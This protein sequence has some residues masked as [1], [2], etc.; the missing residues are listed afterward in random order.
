MVTSVFLVS[1]W[2][3]EGCLVNRMGRRMAWADK[4][5]VANTSACQPPGGHSG[6]APAANWKAGH[7]GSKQRWTRSYKAA[8]CTPAREALGGCQAISTRTR[9][10][11]TDGTVGAGPRPVNQSVRASAGICER[12]GRKISKTFPP[13]KKD[14]LESQ[15]HIFV[16]MEWQRQSDNRM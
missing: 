9:K 15:C 2:Y 5:H 6:R 16:S 3:V 10:Q 8:R 13:A 1:D 14:E 7:Q 12:L 4:E 11:Q